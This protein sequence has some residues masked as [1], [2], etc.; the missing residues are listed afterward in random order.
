M[1][2]T[3]MADKSGAKMLSVAELVY[4][5]VRTLPFFPEKAS[6]IAGL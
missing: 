4:W 3:D 1:A 6:R 2:V 5:R